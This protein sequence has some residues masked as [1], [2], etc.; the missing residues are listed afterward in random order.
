MIYKIEYAAHKSATGGYKPAVYVNG[1][2]MYILE[3]N[4]KTERGALS[5]ARRVAEETAQM[6]KAASGSN[7]VTV[8]KF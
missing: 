8:S 1:K 5:A 4:K 3:R 6:W 2:P 7:Q